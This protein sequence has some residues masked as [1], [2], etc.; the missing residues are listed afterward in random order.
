MWEGGILSLLSSGKVFRVLG[1]LQAA[2]G[3]MTSSGAGKGSAGTTAECPADPLAALALLAALGLGDGLAFGL[4]AA[5]A[6]TLCFAVLDL[7]DFAAFVALL[8]GA[9]LALPFVL[10]AALAFA[11]RPRVLPAC[12]PCF[13]NSGGS[14]S[15][16]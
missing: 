15:F 13:E 8:F 12:S 4:A 10:G 14:M 7:V 6:L 5:L 3:S 2:L 11:L 9:R 16:T 1:F